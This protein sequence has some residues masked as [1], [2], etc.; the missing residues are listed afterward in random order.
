MVVRNQ[1]SPII[2]LWAR[3]SSVIARLECKWKGPYRFRRQFLDSILGLL[4]WK[5]LIKVDF[6]FDYIWDGL[7]LMITELEQ[8]IHWITTYPAGLKLNAHLNAVLSQFF[9]YHIYLWQ[10]YLSVASVY[11]G[12]GFI[13]L[14]CFL[15]LS[16]F[17]AALSDLLQLLTIHIYCFHIYAS[18]LAVLSIKSIQSLWGLFRGKKYNPLR[19]RAD[20]VRTAF[21]GSLMNIVVPHFSTIT[22]D[23]VVAIILDE[24]LQ[25]KMPLA[26]L[27]IRPE[28]DFV[29]EHI[30]GAEHYPQ[31][32]LSRERYETESM[33]R[34]GVQGKL[35]VCGEIHGAGRVVSTFC[36]RGYNALLL[37]GNLNTWRCKYPEGL[38]TTMKDKSTTLDLRKLSTQ[39]V[40]NR[41]PAFE[42]STP[43]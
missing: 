8:L 2:F 16:V 31:I 21:L 25:Q 24:K 22:I 37:R 34:I 35:I 36:D 27:D 43:A 1:L 20:S 30:I 13:P 6:F 14:S 28:E 17:L 7:G 41:K 38:L 3:R 18:K 19:N 40:H 29:K 9:V 26:I 15:G 4:V 11:I 10:T 5:E 33:K 23:E 39:L 12:F 32:L 42:K